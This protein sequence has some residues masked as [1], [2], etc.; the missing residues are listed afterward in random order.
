MREGPRGAVWVAA[1][2]VLGSRWAGQMEAMGWVWMM[3]TVSAGIT[4]W[5]RVGGR[6][7]ARRRQVGRGLEWEPRRWPRLDAL[8]A[9]QRVSPAARESCLTHVRAQCTTC[10][11]QYLL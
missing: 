8:F 10:S 5:R 9:A 7:T 3:S 2:R 11:Y 1:A 6:N 4:R